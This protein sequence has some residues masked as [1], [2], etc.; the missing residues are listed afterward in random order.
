MISVLFSCTDDN[1]IEAPVFPPP[2]VEG[3]TTVPG[4]GLVT[5][6][7]DSG[8]TALF[9]N[10]ALTY[11][12]GDGEP[13]NIPN[14]QTTFTV[15]GLVNGTEYLFA[16]V[17]QKE[18]QATI[19]SSEPV[20]VTATP[21][22]PNTSGPELASFNFMATSNPN[23]ALEDEDITD[24][25]GDIDLENNTV[26]FTEDKVS[27]Y[28]Y[29]DSLVA[30]FSVPNDAVVVVNGEE[31]TSGVSVQDF[32]SPVQYDIT[33]NGITRSYIVT[34]NKSQYATI[35]DDAFRARLVELGMPFDE[36]N[37]LEIN[38]TL[39]TAYNTDGKIDLDNAGITNIK[40]IEF[41]IGTK[42]IDA[43]RNNFP[44][45]NLSKNVGLKNLI[46]GL[47]PALNNVEVGELTLLE[48]FYM[49]D[50]VNLTEMVIQPILDSNTGLKRFYAHGAG[51][52]LVSVNVDKLTSLERLRLN[53]STA[54]VSATSINTMLEAN[55]PIASDLGNLRIYND[56]DGVECAS[57]D[58]STYKCN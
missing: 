39:V 35:P 2:A 14:D 7:W 51:T 18:S 58:P 41:F 48:I 34:V 30:T 21:F 17:A 33:E 55:P 54:S 12:P 8:N 20:T 11:T 26:T 49:N 24:L 36:Q 50:A 13:I 44:T 16:L 47:N 40:G 32:T 56:A 45:I 38:S 28:V 42:E 5:L 46:I 57:Y 6:T 3:F 25:T 19:Q 52:G 37:Q 43:E 27:A 10:Y 15:N 53:E 1:I 31:Q 4:N 9:S 23:M 29:R 22:E